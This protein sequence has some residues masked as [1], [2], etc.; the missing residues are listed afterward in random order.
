MNSIFTRRSIRRFDDTRAVEPEKLERLLRAAMQAP[1]TKNTQPWEFLVVTD[2]RDRLA[3][4]QM[5]EYAG[6]CRFAPA[7][8]V[9]AANTDKE[10]EDWWPQVLSACTQNI[11]LQ[12]VEEGLGAVWLGLYPLQTR[13][14]KMRQYYK[15]PE[16]IMPFSV[17]ALGYSDRS[18]EFIDRYDPSAVNY[19]TWGNKNLHSSL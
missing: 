15:L 4:S 3:I 19:G 17:V 9:T 2:P 13:T 1:S 11:L 5:S 7:L 18:N 12:A 10:S 8:I 16:N 6:V 14:D